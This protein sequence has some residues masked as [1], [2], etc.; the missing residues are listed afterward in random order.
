MQYEKDVFSTEAEATVRS[1]AMGMEGK[2]HAFTNAVGQACYRPG[3]TEKEYMEY[4]GQSDQGTGGLTLNINIMKDEHKLL[5]FDD[6]QHIVYGWASVSTVD[7]MHLVDK[8][9]DVVP[10]DV[11]TKAVNEFMENERVGKT[12]HVGDQTGVIL[13]SMPI[14][15]D[16]AEA[17]GIQTQLE[18]WIVGYKVYDDEV[19][20]MVKSGELRA[21]SIGGFAESSEVEDD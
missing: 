21:F 9:G 14:S 8:Q 11:L 4:Y 5:K 17:L 20:K 1:F 10:M 3:E 7:G 16:I 19:W 12:M 18:G 2:V 15:K 6:E 13:H